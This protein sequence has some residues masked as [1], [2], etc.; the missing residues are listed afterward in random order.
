MNIPDKLIGALVSITL[1]G[2]CAQQ[3]SNQIGQVP[4]PAEAANR[5]QAVEEIPSLYRVNW[6][7]CGT[8]DTQQ[9]CRQNHLPVYYWGPVEGAE[10]VRDGTFGSIDAD[11]IGVYI[12]S[13]G[14]PGSYEQP[15]EPGLYSANVTDYLLEGMEPTVEI[16]ELQELSQDEKVSIFQRGF[17]TLSNCEA[18]TS[19]NAN[20]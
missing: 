17:A 7:L 12:R 9:K 2:S 1:L 8:V 16:L 3:S 20:L 13:R 14:C 4:P 5:P 18:L 15:T 10:V 6:Q 11:K 19:S